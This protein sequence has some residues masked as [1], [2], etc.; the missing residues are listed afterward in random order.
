MLKENNVSKWLFCTAV[1]AL[2]VSCS[3]TRN[4]PGYQKNM[5]SKGNECIDLRRRQTILN[6][7]ENVRIAYNRKDIDLI[8]K[9]YSDDALIGTRKVVKQNKKIN[10]EKIKYQI[11]TKKKYIK[12]LRSIFNKNIKIN[13]IFDNIEVLYHSK[14]DDIYIVTLRQAWNTNKYSDIGF[15]FLVVDFKEDEK[16][17]I[18]ESVLQPEK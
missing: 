2:L 17:I 14:Y 6:F 12:Y 16:I 8:A 1:I 15:L 4:T 9:V 13:V 5:N 11:Q 3:S 10:K 18:L 7:V